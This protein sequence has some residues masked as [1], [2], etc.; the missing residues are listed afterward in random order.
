[1]TVLPY[2]IITTAS[3][4]TMN[5]RHAISTEPI[6]CSNT[7]DCNSYLFPGG[8]MSSTPWPSTEHEDYPLITIHT[9]PATQL[10]FQRLTDTDQVFDETEHCRVF[11]ADGFLVGMKFCLAPGTSEPN[12]LVAGKH[13][14]FLTH[15]NVS[16]T[17]SQAIYVCPQ[18]IANG[19]CIPAFPDEPLPKI[20]TSLKAYKRYATVTSARGNMSIIAIAD[21]SDPM[22]QVNLDLPALMQAFT[23][24]FNSTDAG[25][26]IPSSVAQYF[27]SVQTQLTSEYW[28]MEAYQLFMSLLAFPFWHFNENQFG[29]VR[30]QAETI[31]DTLSPDFYTFASIDRPMSRIMVDP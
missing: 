13:S 3:Q 2:S 27:W 17:T 10:D 9:A 30:L 28:S 6:A 5:S 11:G 15:S 26:P 18:G 12:A 22:Q 25:I 8:L 24:L 29:N 20:V 31:V 7:K 14:S 23:W 19:Q 21:L 1:M 4:L 16:L